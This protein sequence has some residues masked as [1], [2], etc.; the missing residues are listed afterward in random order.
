[1]LPF[2]DGTN[3]SILRVKD[4]RN[5]KLPAAVGFGPNVMYLATICMTNSQCA[6]KDTPEQVEEFH[7]STLTEPTTLRTVLLV[8]DENF[9]VL[10]ETTILTWVDAQYGKRAMPEDAMYETFPLDDARLFTFQENL[11]VSYRDGPNFGY[12]KQVLNR[13]H[14]T[15]EANGVLK[16]SL[17]ASEVNTLC[18][19]RNMALIENMLTYKLQALT[20]VDPVTVV[21]VHIRDKE[22]NLE[23]G[24]MTQRRL[25]A[26]EEG[27]RPP[28][29][30]PQP[31]LREA[32]SAWN[33]S[34]VAMMPPHRRRLK[35]SGR[36]ESDFHG[37]NG[38]MVYLPQLHEYLGI[39]HFHRPPGR[40][41]NDYARFGHHYTHAFFTISDH[42]PF[43]L[44]RLSPE[45]VLQSDTKPQ[46]AEVIQ[47][48][49]GL[50]RLDNNVIVLTYGI[51]DC[52]GAATYIDMKTI[53]YILRDVPKGMEVSDM[54][55][56]LKEVA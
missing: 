19:G 43:H 53:D 37:T 35:S 40:K 10:E 46:D 12:D 2:A 45:L 5:I 36:K 30:P 26:V 8:L 3:P 23:G 48:W 32:E 13:V 18:C 20:W 41:E 24:K 47:F 14:L 28:P 44:K 39:G 52:E 27:R 1:M 7:I 25:S 56:P 29:P 54:L 33:Q 4:N 22:T 42:E 49:S 34:F 6:W 17:L 9:Q 15:R 51:N 31:P 38:F 55:E 21:N 16:A 50:E 11:F